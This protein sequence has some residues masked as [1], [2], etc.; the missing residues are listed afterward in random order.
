MGEGLAIPTDTH[1]TPTFDI[2]PQPKKTQKP[3]KPKRK[4]IKVPK[5]SGSAYI[6]ADEAVHKK[7]GDRLVR[8]TTTASSLEVD[9]DS[10]NI[11][12]TQTKATPNEPSSLG[13]CL[14]GGPRCQEAMGDTTAHT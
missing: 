12:K 7:K 13:T 8:A 10:G 4:N 3:R 5:P 1:P 2:P 11:G 14:G 9:Q 6:L